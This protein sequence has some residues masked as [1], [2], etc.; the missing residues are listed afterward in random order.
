MGTA[1]IDGLR[2]GEGECKGEGGG[3]GERKT[4]GEGG[5]EGEGKT[6]RAREDTP[7]MA[8]HACTVSL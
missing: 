1:C 2:S 3:E 6:E 7:R 5:G 8:T 4:D